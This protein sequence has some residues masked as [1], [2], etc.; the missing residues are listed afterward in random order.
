[1]GGF[2]KYPN[3]ARLLWQDPVILSRNPRTKPPRMRSSYCL[4]L[5]SVLIWSLGL[6]HGATNSFSKS[7]ASS[8]ERILASQADSPDLRSIFFLASAL[9]RLNK[10]AIGESSKSSMCSA[11]SSLLSKGLAST[12]PAQ[13]SM[14]V[15]AAGIL[16]CSIDKSSVAEKLKTAAMGRHLTEIYVRLNDCFHPVAH[17]HR[18][19]MEMCRNAFQNVQACDRFSSHLRSQAGMHIAHCCRARAIHGPRIHA[20]IRL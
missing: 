4:G 2:H 5:V 17:S 7:D 6:A 9:S 19:C 18:D 11:A 1:M 12:N 16:K 14:A 13:I 8:L 3:T 15:R 20:N 10:N